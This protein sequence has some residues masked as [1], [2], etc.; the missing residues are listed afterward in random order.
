MSDLKR[1]E[2]LLGIEHQNW[3]FLH[4]QDCVDILEK[5]DK[6]KQ[7]FIWVRCE[8]FKPL[9]LPSDLKGKMNSAS[10]ITKEFFHP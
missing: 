6:S 7:T 5:M 4:R 3:V 1:V 8:G 10:K 9:H 2:D